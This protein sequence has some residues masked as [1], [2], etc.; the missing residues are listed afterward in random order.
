[1]VIDVTGLASHAGGAPE[2]GISAIAIA[3]LAIADLVHQTVPATL[4]RR[5]AATGAAAHGL[6]PDAILFHSNHPTGLDQHLIRPSAAS[7]QPF[8]RYLPAPHQPR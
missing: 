4:A 7:R 5:A 6:Y 8:A 3:A 2:Q 1:M